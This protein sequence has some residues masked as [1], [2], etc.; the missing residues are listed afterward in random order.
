M[1]TATAVLST[2]PASYRGKRQQA[3]GAEQQLRNLDLQASDFS[4]KQLAYGVLYADS[5]GRTTGTISMALRR[6]TPWQAAQLVAAMARD[7]ITMVCEVPAWMNSKA[8]AV[9]A[10]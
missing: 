5:T 2:I 10:G 1:T 7:G 6:A 9:L 8:L 4:I 3:G